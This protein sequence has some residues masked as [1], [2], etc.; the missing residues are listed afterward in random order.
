[1]ATLPRASDEA[2]AAFHPLGALLVFWL[3]YVVYQHAREAEL[4]GAETPEAAPAVG[5]R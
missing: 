1:M 3:T 4:A 2:I 5:Q